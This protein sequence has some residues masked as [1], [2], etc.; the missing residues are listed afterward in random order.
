M[1]SSAWVLGIL[2]GI[3][4]M[5]ILAGII[6]SVLPYKPRP[7]DEVIVR[8]VCLY[9]VQCEMPSCH[10]EAIVYDAN[11]LMWLCERHRDD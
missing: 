8:H 11:R 7:G 5:A 4:V 10:R 2:A 6:L 3:A 9:D 1:D